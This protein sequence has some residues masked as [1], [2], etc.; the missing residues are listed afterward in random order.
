M[1]TRATDTGFVPWTQEPKRGHA[2]ALFEVQISQFRFEKLPAPP[3]QASPE[4]QAFK[5]DWPKWKQARV[6]VCA[7]GEDG[8]ICEGLRYFAEYGIKHAPAD[9]G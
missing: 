8:E 7:V 9:L 6:V 5:A 1:L 3:D 4:V 2:E